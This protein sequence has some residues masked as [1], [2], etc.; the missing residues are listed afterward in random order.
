MQVNDES[1]NSYSSKLAWSRWLIRFFS[2]F[3]FLV[4]AKYA[5]SGIW[6]YRG[7]S[8][9]EQGRPG[10]AVRYLETANIRDHKNPEL[11]FLKGKAAFEQGVKVQDSAWFEGAV[12]QFE[13]AARGIP[14]YGRVWMYLALSRINMENAS[15]DGLTNLEWKF[16]APIIEKAYQLETNSAW[17]NYVAGS[18]L[19]SNV[20]HLSAEERKKGFA[21]LKQ[22]TA[23]LPGEYLE[24]AL[25]FLW[26]KFSNP[27]YLVDVTPKDLESYRTLIGFS[28]SRQIWSLLEN[29]YSVYLRFKEDLYSEY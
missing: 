28:E 15:E 1:K 2:V 11:L 16:I 25:N 10:V 21:Y 29:A 8:Q 20:R 23:M 4:S 18:N 17:M 22:G 6:F 5:W 9:L 27:K 7:Q 19:L 14:Y 3:M 12:M 13:E 24:P 26:T